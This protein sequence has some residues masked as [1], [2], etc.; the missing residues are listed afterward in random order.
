MYRDPSAALLLD[1]RRRFKAVLD[2]LLAMIL[3]GITLAR[4]V[5]LTAQRDGN[6]RIGQVNLIAAQD[7]DSARRGDLGECC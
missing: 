4:T 3:D 6:F 7:L 2:V 1:L 5:E